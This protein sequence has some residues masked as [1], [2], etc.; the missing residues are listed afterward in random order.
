MPILGPSFAQLESQIMAVVKLMALWVRLPHTYARARTHTHTHTHTPFLSVA[1][2]FHCKARK[3]LFLPTW[4]CS[5]VRKAL[6]FPPQP[7]PPKKKTASAVENG[8][9]TTRC[10]FFCMEEEPPL[11]I[12]PVGWGQR[13]VF[14]WRKKMTHFLFFGDNFWAMCFRLVEW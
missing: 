8:Q 5:W 11:R 2:T 1:Q 13:G 14:Q 10:L 6:P 7:P 9:I 12:C 4:C 3:N